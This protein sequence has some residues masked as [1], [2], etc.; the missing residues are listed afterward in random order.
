MCQHIDV[1]YI[2]MSMCRYIGVSI[3]LYVDVSKCRFFDILKRLMNSKGAWENLRNSNGR[4]RS[5]PNYIVNTTRI[6]YEGCSTG[7]REPMLCRLFAASGHTCR[8]FKQLR[9][10]FVNI[11][12]YQGNSTSLSLHPHSDVYLDRN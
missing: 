7:C 6:V 2:Y 5:F 1:S 9:L 12:Q 3:Y 4:L 11:P 8:G 10:V